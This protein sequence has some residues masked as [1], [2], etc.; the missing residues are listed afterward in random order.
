MSRRA[1]RRFRTTPFDVETRNV[2]VVVIVA[3]DAG[4]LDDN[5][6]EEMDE[7]SVDDPDDDRRW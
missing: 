1:F 6:G 5:E 3:S 2:V 7:D 4:R